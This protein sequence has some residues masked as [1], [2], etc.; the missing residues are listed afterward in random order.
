MAML[1]F[2]EIPCLGGPL[3]GERVVD[4]GDWFEID[5]PKDAFVLDPRAPRTCRYILVRRTNHL[6]GWAS[7]CYRAVRWD[8]KIY[9]GQVLESETVLTA[10][11]APS[12]APS[13]PC[14]PSSAG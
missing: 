5:L 14:P 10:S 9:A 8:A 13:S 1:I 7:L 6:T 4:A 2:H 11:P 3:D 12:A